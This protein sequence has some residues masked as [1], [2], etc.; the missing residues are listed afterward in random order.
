MTNLLRKIFIK[1]YKNVGNSKVREKHGVLAACVGIFTN[2]LLTGFKIFI[3]IITFSISIIAD[4]LN[5]L[6][7]M[8]SCIVNLFGFKLANKPA[9]KEHPFGHERIEYIAGLIISF[10]IIALAIVLGYT[11][12]LKIVNKENNT[13]IQ[14][15]TFIVLGVAIIVKLWQ[16]FFYKKIA[17][18]IDSVSLKASAQDS[19]NDVI[20]TSVVLIVSIICY[21]TNGEINLDSYAGILVA[22]FIV[23]SGIKLII[24]TANPLIGISPNHEL[25][26]DIVKDIESYPGVLGIHDLM[27]HS[28][29]PTKLFMTLHVEIDCSIDMLKAH[30]MIDN[31]ENEVGEKHHLL[32]TIH[33]DPI[34]TKSEE[35]NELKLK[36]KD[37]LLSLDNSLT[38]H[39]FRIVKGETHT[40]VLFDVVLSYDSPLKEEDVLTYLKQEYKKIDPKY[41]LVV[42]IDKDFVGR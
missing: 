1:D 26:K 24:E 3:G 21:S 15:S 5:N 35:T 22:L 7:D 27:V 23:Y 12:I 20:S 11:S 28:Y 8:A 19:L 25:V 39:D 40:N 33:M 2:L 16:S 34:D 32:L 4:A 36:T 6:T 29:G 18:L 14:I 17:K 31:I 38:F 9:D 10:I 42:K 37:M 41:N 13:V 30:D